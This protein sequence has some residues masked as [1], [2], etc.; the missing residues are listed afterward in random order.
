MNF[1]DWSIKRYLGKDSAAGDL[2]GDMSRDSEFPKTSNAK[3]TIEKYLKSKG[4]CDNAIRT[5]REVFSVYRARTT[6]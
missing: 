1:Y 5:F 6:D 3:I 2:A 4:A